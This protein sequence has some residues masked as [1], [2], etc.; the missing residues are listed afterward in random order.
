MLCLSGNF[1]SEETTS[2][3]INLIISTPE[4]NLYSVHKLFLALK[5][6]LGQV[7]IS[8]NSFQEGLVKVG[9]YILGEFANILVTNSVQG[10][11]GETITVT[12]EDVLE[13]INDIYYRR[14]SNSII[15]EYLLNCLLKLSVK[16]PNY[17]EKIRRYI[18][19]DTKSNFYE[20]QQRAVEYSIFTKIQNYNLKSE[21][22]KN[23]PNSKITK[24]N[25]IKKYF[26]T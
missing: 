22:T 13:V 20:V 24:E 18:E 17:E 10:P 26:L 9:V 5:N 7:T 11:D 21:M 15:K 6:N 1:V 14:Y 3:V 4:L 12:E 16:F 25:E 8:S 23:I 2:S 19:E